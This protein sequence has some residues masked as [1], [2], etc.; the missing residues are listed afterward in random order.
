MMEVTISKW[1]NSLGVRLPMALSSKGDFQPGTKLKLELKDGEI[2]LKPINTRP[3]YKLE[4]LIKETD[5]AFFRPDDLEIW[6]NDK[7]VG[8]EVI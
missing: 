1:G 3:K 7:P 6:L 4:Q 8:K 5:K 2:V